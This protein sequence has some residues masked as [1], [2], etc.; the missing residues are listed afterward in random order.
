VIGDEWTAWGARNHPDFLWTA[1]DL[2]VTSQNQNPYIQWDDV[3]PLLVQ[4]AST[5]L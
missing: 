2:S 5:D 3:R 4:S 1:V